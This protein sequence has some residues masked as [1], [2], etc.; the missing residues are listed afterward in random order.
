MK[1][2]LLF[3][4]SSLTFAGEDCVHCGRGLE[5]DPALSHLEETSKELTH[6][7]ASVSQVMSAPCKHKVFPLEEMNASLVKMTG[8]RDKKIAGV[9]FDDENPELLQAFK[10][11]TVKKTDWL[12]KLTALA[13]SGGENFQKKF[14]VN[15]SCQKVLCAVDK[16][17]GQYLG[18]KLLYLNLE[19]GFNGSEYLFPNAGRYTDQELD[20]VLLTLMD[21]PA[22]MMP[23]F[24]N[25][26]LKKSTVEDEETVGDNYV[27]ANATITVFPV[28]TR[29]PSG[30]RYQTLAHELG[31]NLKFR[32]TRALDQEWNALSSWVK[33]GE[34]W[35]A[36]VF[37]SCFASKYSMKSPGEDFAEVASA[38]RYNGRALRKQC[39]PKYNFMR[40]HVFNGVEYLE[41]SQCSG[42]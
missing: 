10:N 41:E 6:W 29:V 21:M 33:L 3:T 37:N 14:F 32:L 11:L 7:S 8:K 17:W 36:D 15:P 20:D 30:L 42:K 40:D 18:R 13:G 25:Q 19:F 23:M 38:Y 26:M 34:E 31:H 24:K 2:L 39:E 9:F 16:I 5:N 4:L 12:G 28:W 35:Q 27:L 1:W 22:F